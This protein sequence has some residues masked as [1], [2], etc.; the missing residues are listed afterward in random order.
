MSTHLAIMTRA[1]LVSTRK[2][3]RMM[4][5]QADLDGFQ[6]LMG[7]LLQDCCKG[8]AEICAPLVANLTC[9]VPAPKRKKKVNV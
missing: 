9:C 7:F 3:G 1:S 2:E 5:Y 8:R 4:H 6:S